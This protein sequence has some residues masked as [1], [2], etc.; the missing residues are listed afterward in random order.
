MAVVDLSDLLQDFG[1]SPLPLPAAMAEPRPVARAETPPPVDWPKADPEQD[2][3]AEIAKAEAAIEERLT[4]AHNA[5]L[6]ELKLAHA[7]EL[8][9]MLQNFGKSAGETIAARMSEM[10]SRIGEQS[11]SAATRILGA[12]LSEELQKRSLES[13]AQSIRAAV[14]DREAVRI[15]VRGPQSLF[16][17]L[18]ESLGDRA[19]EFDFIE[20]PGF[21]LVVN[22]D[23]NLFETRL[24][25]W[26][27]VLSDI[28][29]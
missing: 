28:L 9:A 19:G 22:I 4:L 12:F 13:L 10:E 15:E 7:T 25:E 27:T 3:Q 5:A 8:E 2:V 1:A 29:S 11:A 17:T 14:T 23:G 20:A 21:D 6:D 24:S 26:A 16:A 18:S